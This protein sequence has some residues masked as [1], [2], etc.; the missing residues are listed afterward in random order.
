MQ[1]LEKIFQIPFSLPPVDQTGYST[2]I[3]VLTASAP[4][5]EAPA[6]GPNDDSGGDPLPSPGPAPAAGSA[7]TRPQPLPAAPVIERFDPLALTD[8][9]RQLMTLLGPPLVTTPRSIKRLVNSYGLLN[10]LRGSQHQRDLSETRHASTGST[11]YPY[12]AAIALLGTL[13]AFPDLSPAFFPRLLQVSSETG[14]GSW[15]Q[16]LKQI[17]PQHTGDGW[18]SE[19]LGP[20]ATEAEALRWKKLA[21]ALEKLTTDAADAGLP[22]PEPLEAWTEWVIPAGRL[23][24]ETGRAVVTLSHQLTHGSG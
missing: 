7:Q 24:F 6:A 17:N 14:S 9:E 3:N 15:P 11:Y 4:H 2:M 19:I 8:D 18:S 20:L 22:L 5:A 16:F 1:Y 21:S 12:R 13:I 10:A 23:S